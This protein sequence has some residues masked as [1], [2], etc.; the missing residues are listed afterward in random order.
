MTPPVK[1]TQIALAIGESDA[2]LAATTT[3]IKL[4]NFVNEARAEFNEAAIRHSD[5]AIKCRDELDGEY[6]GIS[7]VKNSRGP[8]TEVILMTVDQCKLVAMRESKSVRR[9][10]LA[11]LNELEAKAAGPD[12]TT[13]ESKLLMIQGLAAKQ[14]ALLADNKR[15]Q[16]ERDKAI[17]T[18]AQIGSKR[19]ATAMATAAAAKRQTDKLKEQLGFCAKHASVIAVEKATGKKFATQDWRKLRAWCLKHGVMAITVPDTRWGEAKAWPAGAWLEM[20]GVD[21]T[22]LFGEVA[23]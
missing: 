14:L 4:M 21:L 1:T 6:Y 12:L 7:V 11:R 2:P 22:A 23:A 16:L 10:V 15:I 19:E 8:A 5:L 13:D 9:R 20:F 18:K 17:A 3:S